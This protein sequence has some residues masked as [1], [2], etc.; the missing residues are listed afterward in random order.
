MDFWIYSLAGLAVGFIVG[1]TGMGGGSLMTP[2][3]ILLFNIKPTLAIGTDLLFAAIT[4]SAGIW[5]HGKRGNI[6]W[7][8]V[9]LL[10]LGSVPM[11]IITV[12]FLKGMMED[13]AQ[14]KSMLTSSLGIALLLTG[15]AVIF[16]D[17]LLAYTRATL[18]LTHLVPWRDAATVLAGACLG[19]LV[20]LSSVGAGVLGTMVLFFLYPWT[21][22][23]RIVG[24]D[25][26]HAV[27]LTA[28]AGLG[29]LHLG[30]VDFVLL[31][32]LLV[33]SLPGIYLGS[34]VSHRIPDKVLRPVLGSV[35]I[36]F[37]LK[38]LSF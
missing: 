24:T 20:T 19:V 5:V 37:G 32:S 7:R 33:G 30:N 17:G 21:P 12:M 35:L 18:N 29:H 23:V 25:I 15:P 4:K 8:I 22:A 11:A 36:L 14:V 13:E 1:L 10:S 31:G 6:N 28:V 16:R 9:R 26:A 3:L 34:H 27:P 38:F 2:L